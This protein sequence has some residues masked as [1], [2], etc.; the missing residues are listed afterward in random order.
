[1]ALADTG[2]HQIETRGECG[3]FSRR[4]Y[5]Y[6]MEIAKEGSFSK[7]AQKLYVSQPALSGAIKKL[8]KDLYGIPL[9]DRAVTPVALTPAGQYYLEQARKIYELRNEIEHHFADLAG[10]RTG[11]INIGTSGYFCAYLLPDIIRGYYRLNPKCRINVTET[12]ASGMDAGLRSG[13]FNITIDVEAL[14]PEMFESVT[15]G[16]EYMVMAVPASF[17]VNDRM[18]QYQISREAILNRSFLDDSVPAVDLSLVAKEPFLMLKKHHDAYRRSMDICAHSGF[19]PNIVMSF[20]Q[21]QT[22]YNVARSGQTGIIFF[23][24]GLLKYTENTEKLCYYKLGDPLAKRAILLTMK[25]YPGVGPTVD[26]FIKYLMLAK[27]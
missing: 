16:Y 4:E 12:D 23:R 5:E 22:A 14:D 20:D 18:K 11:I 26:D 2:N 8:E 6:V 9:F 3:M 1:M 15:L 24:D 7:A 10:I 13:Q 19:E 25:R 27:K 17:E 21:L